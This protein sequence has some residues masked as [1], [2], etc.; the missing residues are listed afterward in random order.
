MYFGCVSR[1]EAEPVTKSVG[2]SVNEVCSRG[3]HYLS[4]GTTRSDV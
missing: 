4:N 1:C 3:I 2:K